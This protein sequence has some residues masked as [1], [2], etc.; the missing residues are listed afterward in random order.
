MQSLLP[1]LADVGAPI[2]KRLIQQKMSGLAAAG[3]DMAVDTIAKSLKVESTP[4]AIVDAYN[5]APEQVGQLIRDVES[6]NSDVWAQYLIAATEARAELFAREDSKTFFHDGWRPA[7]C[8]LLI[9]LFLSN[10][11]ILP[12]INAVFKTSIPLTDWQHIIAFASVW[13][14]IYGGGHTAKSVFGSK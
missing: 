14:V 11:T 1:I 5:D 10:A 9:W 12:I 7:M 13:L 2:L 8:W 6:I 4:E 3:A